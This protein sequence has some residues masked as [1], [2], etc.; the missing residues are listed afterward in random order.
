MFY[1]SA[2][3]RGFWR[4]SILGIVELCLGSS[5][6]LD[7]L[8][9]CNDWPGIL[10]IKNGIEN[11]LCFSNDSIEFVPSSNKSILFYFEIGTLLW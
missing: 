4:M 6:R 1:I 3:P 8:M 7:L 11:F 9:V 5:F 10:Q 2:N